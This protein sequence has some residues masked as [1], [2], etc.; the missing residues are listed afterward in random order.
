MGHVG[1][2]VMGHQTVAKDC[3]IMLSHELCCNG[4]AA[5]PFDCR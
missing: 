2:F 5:A 4:S 1:K 3:R